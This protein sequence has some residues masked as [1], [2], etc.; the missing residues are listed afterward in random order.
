MWIKDFFEPED[1]PYRFNPFVTVTHLC[2]SDTISAWEYPWHPHKEEYEITFILKGEGQL[3][4]EDSAVGLSVGDI[5]VTAPG[6][7]HRYTIP[8]GGNMEYFAMRFHQDP[9]DGPIQS[10][11]AKLAP[12]AVASS[13]K[14]LDFFRSSIDLLLDTNVEKDRELTQAVCLPLL[15][16]AQRIFS[17]RARTIAPKTCSAADIMRYI[18]EN[19]HEKITLQSLGKRFSIS[20]SHLSRMFSQ[21]YHCSPINYLINAR[22][23]RA[24]EYL[25]KTNKPVSEI[26]ELVGYENSFYFINLFTKRT[27]CSPT[28]YREH[29]DS[30]NLPK[31]SGDHLFPTS[32]R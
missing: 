21:T 25:G 22:I 12:A 14:Y 20:P 28:E 2:Y 11:L 32:H 1:N 27:G 6:V 31:Q 17:S 19:C 18:T 26:S 7:F 13:G 9:K 15:Q 24:T 23:A 16:L 30:R 29:L 4:V 10:A 5:C 8:E 3:S